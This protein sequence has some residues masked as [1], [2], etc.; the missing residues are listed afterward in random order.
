V[1]WFIELTCIS[2]AVW[3]LSDVFFLTFARNFVLIVPY[4]LY[5]TVGAFSC[6]ASPTLKFSSWD[7]TGARCVEVCSGGQSMC[8]GL[9]K[10]LVAGF[11]PRVSWFSP[12]SVHVGRAMERAE[13]THMFCLHFGLSLSVTPPVQQS[14]HYY[15]HHHHHHRH[16]SATDTVRSRLAVLWLAIS[17]EQQRMNACKIKM[18]LLCKNEEKPC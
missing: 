9:F 4:V 17:V 8:W 13:L 7:S 2:T 15:Y 3:T 18:S 11:S 6:A 12:R 1:F 16:S 5:I 10:R 14:Y